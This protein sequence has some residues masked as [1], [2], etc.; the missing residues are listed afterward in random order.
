MNLKQ[1]FIMKM[2]Y[3]LNRKLIL[4][5]LNVDS[6]NTITDNLGWSLY[7]YY[8]SRWEVNPKYKFVADDF[9]NRVIEQISDINDITVETGLAGVA[10][11]ISH[12]VR[13]KY[14]EG[15]INEILEEVDNAI[16][17]KLVFLEYKNGVKPIPK[18][19]L[20][21]LLYYLYIRYRECKSLE[22]KYF[23]QELTIRTLEMLNENLQDEFFKENINY[24]LLNY[25]LPLFLCVISKIYKL[26]IYNYRI[27]KILDRNINV[28]LSSYPVLHANRLFLLYGLI[29]IKPCL[30]KFV[31]EFES[32]IKLLKSNI[33]I[34]Y[35]LYEEFNN[36]NVYILD[37]ISSVYMMLYSLKKEYPNYSFN[38]NPQ[39]IY[40]RV[41]HSDIWN[42]MLNND[43]YFDNHCKLLDGYLGVYLTMLHIKRSFL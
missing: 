41:S 15:D 16:F 5:K 34:N 1:I 38:F 25:N 9:L 35:I 43:F 19:D 6:F 8:L 10:L 40:T 18:A 33:D 36:Q 11:G 13:E 39:L 20:I 31:K 37:G 2:I 12:L 14:V 28:I 17:K 29:S 42:R 22:N 7:F 23:F 27:D 32:H 26:N 30:I 3:T 21:L 4:S 24:S